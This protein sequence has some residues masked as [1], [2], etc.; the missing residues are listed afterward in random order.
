M[1]SAFIKIPRTIPTRLYFSEL[2]GALKK[3]IPKLMQ[4]YFKTTEILMLIAIKTYHFYCRPTH[5]L[6]LDSF[7]HC[8]LSSLSQI[9]LGEVARFYE[10]CMHLKKYGNSFI[11]LFHEIKLNRSRG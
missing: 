8:N 9:L 5:Y 7:Q 4:Y 6:I 3:L 1:F 11:I 10:C 2:K